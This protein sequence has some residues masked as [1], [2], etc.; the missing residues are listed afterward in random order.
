MRKALGGYLE[1]DFL[2][3]GGIHSSAIAVNT[4]RNGLRYILRVK[5]YSKIYIPYF[6]CDVVL[7]TIKQEGLKYE[8]YCITES[9]EPVFD[10]GIVKSDEVFLYT[11][12]FGVKDR[13]VD[14]LVLKLKN[15]IIDNAQAFY[16]KLVDGVN[17]F[18][19]PRKFLG[20]PDGGYVYCNE[21]LLIDK[22]DVS[23]DRMSHLLKRVE[24][25]AEEGYGDFT[26]NE[27]LLDDLELMKM[28]VLSNKLVNTVDHEFIKEVR[29][30]NYKFLY[31]SFKGI[32][33]MDLPLEINSVPLVFPLWINKEIISILHSNRCYTA[34][35]WPNVLDWTTEKS[36]EYKLTKE[37]VYLPIDQGISLEEIKEIIDII[38]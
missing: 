20:V 3:K 10:F 28:S 31:D 23:Y 33:K 24:L 22:I 1:F 35:Y 4:G 27:K 29:R 6:T 34:T 37:V 2:S 19:S 36:L 32:N 21:E 7:N 26:D 8:F 13:Y 12:Y 16:A 17:S 25:G 9:L 15:I 18:Y 14:Q 38:K 11:N 5:K 30:R